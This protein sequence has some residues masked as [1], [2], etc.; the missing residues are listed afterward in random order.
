MAD[1]SDLPTEGAVAATTPQTDSGI[2]PAT[3]FSTSGAPVQLVPD[4]DP[5]HPA[6][7]NDPRRNTTALMNRIDFNDPT[8]SGPEAT[9]K[10]LAEQAKG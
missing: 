3:T 8:L 4:V 10:N 2:A 7:D 9:A 1:K 5:E 6:V